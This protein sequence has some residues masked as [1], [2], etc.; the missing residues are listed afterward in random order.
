M[1]KS[2]LEI[3]DVVIT[4]TGMGAVVV[5]ARRRKDSGA[6]GGSALLGGAQAGGGRIQIGL[7]GG[8]LSIALGGTNQGGVARDLHRAGLLLCGASGRAGLLLGGASGIGVA[9]EKRC[10]GG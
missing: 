9:I 7:G 4:V 5:V 3:A 2:V 10:V 8:G 6:L 1:K